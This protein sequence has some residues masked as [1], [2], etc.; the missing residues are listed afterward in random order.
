ML[1][2]D[3]ALTQFSAQLYNSV[4][5]NPAPT[6]DDWASFP[7]PTGR[8]DACTLWIKQPFGD[9][10]IVSYAQNLISVELNNMVK[11]RQS[12]RALA[13]QVL[14]DVIHGT[15]DTVEGAAAWPASESTAPAR[16]WCSWWSPPPTTNNSA[17]HRC[18][19]RSTAG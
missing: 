14:D 19:S 3:I 2:S 5:G 12:Q 16:T 4:A 1:R 6:A 13:G 8:R 17:A 18:R 15:L 11:Q 10:G 7:I 9:T